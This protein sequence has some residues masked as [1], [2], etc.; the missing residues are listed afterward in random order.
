[1]MLTAARGP[2]PLGPANCKLPFI[3]T[4][5][6]IVEI[7]VSWFRAKSRF[8]V[9]TRKYLQLNFVVILK[10]IVIIIYSSYLIRNCCELDIRDHSIIVVIMI[11]VILGM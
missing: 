4:V 10:I 8:V 5:N 9:L 2:R 3:L 1:M 6:T 11:T 7:E